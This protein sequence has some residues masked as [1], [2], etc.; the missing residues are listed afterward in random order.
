MRIIAYGIAVD[1]LG[2]RTVELDLAPPATV[3][4]L[5]DFLAARHPRF[6][7]L[8]SLRVAVNETYADPDTVIR[9]GDEV[10]LIPPVSGG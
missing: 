1:I 3:E 2:G 9:A 5:L 7:E 4:T 10:V 6:G 8:A